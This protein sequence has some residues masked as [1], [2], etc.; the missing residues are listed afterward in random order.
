MTKA[1]ITLR[2]GYRCAPDG[3]TIVTIPFGETVDGK[4]AE[5]ALADR[6]ASRMFPDMETKPAAPVERKRGRPRKGAK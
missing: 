3:H 1:K 4:I 6:A 2:E 5:W